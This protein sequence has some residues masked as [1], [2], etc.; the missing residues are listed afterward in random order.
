ME[1]AGHRLQEIVQGDPETVHYRQMAPGG[2]STGQTAVEEFLE[3]T[4]KFTPQV[5]RCGGTK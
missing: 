5:T 3:Q 4:S 2:W 1:Q